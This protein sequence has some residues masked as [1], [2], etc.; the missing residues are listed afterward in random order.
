MKL[1][2]IPAKI[3]GWRLGPSAASPAGEPTPPSLSCQLLSRKPPQEGGPCLGLSPLIA[4]PNCCH[5]FVGER[6]RPSPDLK[7]PIPISNHA[8]RCSYRL[9][10]PSVL[11]VI[12]ILLLISLFHPSFSRTA[13]INLPGLLRSRTRH[14]PTSEFWERGNDARRIS[15]TSQPLFRSKAARHFNPG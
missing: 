15:M 13:T 9:P 2:A 6:L 8:T 11:I 12:L 14:S 3:P 4:I 5:P 7:L 10:Y 1:R